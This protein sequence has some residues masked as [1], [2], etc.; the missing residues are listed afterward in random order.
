MI[1]EEGIDGS[2]SGRHRSGTLDPADIIAVRLQAV[3][4]DEIRGLCSGVPGRMDLFSLA[5][6]A[7]NL[8]QHYVHT[9]SSKEPSFQPKPCLCWHAR[10]LVLRV[11]T[12]SFNPVACTVNT[13]SVFLMTAFAFR[14]G[15]RETCDMAHPIWLP[16]QQ[17]GRVDVAP[18]TVFFLLSIAILNRL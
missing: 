18:D 2:R 1:L 6:F 5:S 12:C 15:G 3:P 14:P 17:N 16:R 11:L 8:P 7:A 9:L 13:R 10:P 4:G